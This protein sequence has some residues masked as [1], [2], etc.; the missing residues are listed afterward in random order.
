MVIFIFPLQNLSL[1]VGNTEIL[2]SEM[3][4]RVQSLYPDIVQRWNEERESRLAKEAERVKRHEEVLKRI[5]EREASE[6]ESTISEE[7]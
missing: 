1:D 6:A 4:E 7:L 3:L 5:A 2:G